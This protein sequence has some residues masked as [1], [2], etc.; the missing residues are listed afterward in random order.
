MD[1]SGFFGLEAHILPPFLL[2][3][4]AELR[5]GTCYDH[6]VSESFFSLLKWQRT[7]RT[8]QQGWQDIFYYIET[9]H[10]PKRKHVGN[11]MLSPVDF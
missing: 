8:Q 5:R 1:L 3:R 6:D 4:C 2:N 10:N 9:F 7:Y 11:G